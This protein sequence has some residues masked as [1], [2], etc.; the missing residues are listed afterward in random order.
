LQKKILHSISCAAAFLWAMGIH[1]SGYAQVDFRIHAGN[2]NSAAVEVDR[3]SINLTSVLGLGTNIDIKSV[4]ATF[5]KSGTNT[6]SYNVGI[7]NAKIIGSAGQIAN[8]L[9]LGTSP[10]AQLSANYTSIYSSLL[11]LL[12]AGLVNIRYTINTSSALTWRAGTYSNSLEFRLRSL[13]SISY[14]QTL[15]PNISIVVDPFITVSASSQ[16]LTLTIND[17][18]YFRTK[19]LLPLTHRL[20][21]QSTV[22]PAVQTKAESSSFSYTAGYA[23]ANIPQVQASVLS[24]TLQ[25]PGNT[26]KTIQTSNSF[27]QLS[28]SVGHD[29][30]A[31]NR[32]DLELQYSLTAATLKSN[33]LNKGQYTLNL[34]HRISDVETSLATAQEVPTTIQVTVADL[35]ELK[36][37][38]NDVRLEFKTAEDYRKGVYVDLP[39]HFTLSATAPYDVYVQA[40][41]SNLH[42]GASSI[43]VQSITISSAADNIPEL[44]TTKLGSTRQK[45]L[46]ATPVIDR[47]VNVRYGISAKDAV[48]LLNKPAGQYSATV[49]YSLIAP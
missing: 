4:N 28:P 46:S 3:Q 8:L 21:I 48:N 1:A 49:T 32:N 40:T 37:N 31:G 30:V 25:L 15:T 38:H 19:T 45:I 44:L 12:S 29:L 5:T 14:P 17:L 7:V 39:A 11:S 47:K 41:N 24:T 36:I 10:T 9:T 34:R 43:P 33:F 2:I 22:K 23:G 18:N 26:S 16:Q 6:A 35:A 27:Q 42:N 20:N 13:L